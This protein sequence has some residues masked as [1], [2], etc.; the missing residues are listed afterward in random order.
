[1]IRKFFCSAAKHTAVFAVVLFVLWLLLF[2]SALI[3][4]DAIRGNMEK[5]ANT[6]KEHST[7]EFVKGNKFN[8]IADYYADALWLN[9]A[10]NIGEGNS[11]KSVIQTDYYDGEGL[12]ENAGLY[13]TI[14]EGKSPN[15]DYTRYWHGT[16]MF[17]RFGHLLTDV[18]GVK[19]IGFIVF[20]LL[21][22]LTIFILARKK[23]WDLAAILALSLAA[24]QSWNIRLSMEYQ[25]SFI[26]AFVFIP[27]FL[28]LERRGDKW[29]TILSVVSGTAVA[30]FDFLTTE[31]VTILIP[32]A[33]VI[34]VRTK[35]NRLGS[36]K[37]NLLLLLKCGICWV[38][39]YGGA[40]I[41]KWLIA[42]MVTGEN[43]FAL[44]FSSAE[45]HT[46]GGNMQTIDIE[47]RPDNFI[48]GLLAN[49][50][51]LF[52]GTERVQPERVMLGLIICLL[53]IFS[54]WYMLRKK[55]SSKGTTSLLI[56]GGLVFV[57]FLVLNNHSY[58]HEFF[59]YRTL[60]TPIFALLASVWLNIELP[61]K[62]GRRK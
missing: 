55:E 22:G 13:L 52:G 51:V 26:L 45:V 36:L 58:V 2:L 1:M 10:W 47:N 54:V 12:G 6:Y 59:V 32:L 40:F 44:A 3:P 5:S 31:T 33:L 43:A 18:E 57:R 17:I 62:K 56:L 29:L 37:E 35:E 60:I 21:V 4:N 27:L 48:S 28:I 14:T 41:V 50:T 16:A 24:V 39:S 34:A 19:L 23:H 11:L 38:L 9:I 61:H 8:S 7:Y 49:L 15:T 46:L 25:P 30:F 20:L 53:L 42:S